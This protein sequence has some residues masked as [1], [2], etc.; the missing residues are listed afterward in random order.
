MICTNMQESER[1]IALADSIDDV[2]LS[3]EG[4][5]TISVALAESE[6]A[7][8]PSLTVIANVLD[9]CKGALGRVSERI[10]EL[11]WEAPSAEG[12]CKTFTSCTRSWTARRP[13]QEKSALNATRMLLIVVF[14]GRKH[15]DT[16]APIRRNP[17]LGCCEAS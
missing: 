12:E 8:K 17:P 7:D 10:M 9:E 13:I 4:L 6:L 14:P 5:S 16:R 3:L 15:T 11:P 2:K 1:A